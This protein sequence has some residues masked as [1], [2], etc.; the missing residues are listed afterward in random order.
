MPEN[1]LIFFAT[2]V[3]VLVVPGPDFVVVTRNTVVRGRAAG[4]A[5][6]AGIA[7]GLAGYTALAVLGLTVVIATSETALAVL[8]FAGAAYLVFLGARALLALWR[9]RH[10]PDGQNA[11]GDS[12]HPAVESA[13][14]GAGAHSA[15][16]QGLLNNSLNPKALVFFLGFLPQFVTPG[17]SATAQ[18]LFLGSCV[19]ALAVVWWVCYVMAIDRISALLRRRRVRQGVELTSGVALTAFGVAL[20][21]AA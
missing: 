6:A 4:L 7:T 12:G 14:G 18:T 13:S 15:F 3:I 10:R 17:D 9:G 19:V 20:A 21:V 5:T 16:L 2:T 1:L 11:P 8:R